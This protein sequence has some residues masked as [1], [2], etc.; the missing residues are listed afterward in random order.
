MNVME[1]LGSRGGREGGQGF[2]YPGIEQVG[3]RDVVYSVGDTG[4]NVVVA[5]HG[6]GCLLDL[7]WWSLLQVC[8]C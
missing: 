2:R 6:V 5:G 8:G 4:G 7:S 3:G 1:G